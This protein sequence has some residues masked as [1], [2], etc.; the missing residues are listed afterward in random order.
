M[1][2]AGCSHCFCTVIPMHMLKEI[3]QNG[4]PAQRSWAIQTIASSERLRA[5]REIVAQIPVDSPSI[6]GEM[7]RTI[8]DA[9]NTEQLPGKIVRSEGQP[10]TS[11]IAVNEAY[12]GA[13]ATYEMFK[14]VFKR[15][16]IDDRGL[17]LDSTVHYSR[18]Y[19]NAFWD[20][21]QMCYGDGDGRLFNRFT[22]AL[23]VIGHELAH[24]VTQ[25]EAGL[26]YWDQ[27]GALNEHFSD[28]FGTLVKQRLLR[29]S[30]KNADWLIGAGLF[31]PQVRGTALRSMRDPGSAYNDQVLGK[32]PQPNHMKRF[33]TT[34]EDNGGVHLNSGI[35]NRAF[36]VACETLGDQWKIGNIWYITLRDRLR[37]RSAFVECAKLTVAVAGEQYGA[38]SKEQQ[39]VKKGW[40]A[41]GIA[42]R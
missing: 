1:K 23:D 26:V 38:S 36:Y 11:D 8:F 2:H 37:S 13:G 10:E 41:V 15:N 35:P 17:R 16:S 27:P 4:D 25:Y 30:V 32:D 6:A 14:T 19:D 18:G 28:V 12:D 22:A 21:R 7:R 34:S 33:I 42:V 20:G 40:S 5:R 29:Q 3:A 31:T 24:G 39:A 9:Q